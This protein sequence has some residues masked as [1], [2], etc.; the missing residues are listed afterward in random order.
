MDIL[1]VFIDEVKRHLD[2]K[3]KIMRYDRGGEYYGKY[4]ET[5]QCPDPFAKLL[6]SHGICAQYTMPGTPQQ[7]CVDERRNCTLMNMIRPMLNYNNVSL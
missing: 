1:K 6:E 5:V 7:N 2:R 4:N 3:I